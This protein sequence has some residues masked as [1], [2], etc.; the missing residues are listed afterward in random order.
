MHRAADLRSPR[1]SRGPCLRR[2]P[3]P[4]EALPEGIGALHDEKEDAE[5]LCPMER[6]RSIENDRRKKR[7]MKFN[8]YQAYVSYGG[9][10]GGNPNFKLVAERVSADYVKGFF[11]SQ[12][13]LKKYSY[14]FSTPEDE[15]GCYYC[16]RVEVVEL[17]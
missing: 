13:L 11:L 8:V 2:D 16:Y 15:M 3:L 10:L 1:A 12:P 6:R 17:T 7:Y 14:G 9:S 5:R 4:G